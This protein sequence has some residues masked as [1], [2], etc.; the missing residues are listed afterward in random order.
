[1]HITADKLFDPSVAR[2]WAAYVEERKQAYGRLSAGE[3]LT[4]KILLRFA[5]AVEQTE[6]RAAA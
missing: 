3:R 4:R 6:R 2:G 1:M 5:N